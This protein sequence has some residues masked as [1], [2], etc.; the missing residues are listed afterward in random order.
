MWGVERISSRERRFRALSLH[1]GSVWACGRSGGAAVARAALILTT[2]Q[3]ARLSAPGRHTVG[4]IPGLHLRIL[5]PPAS[6][7]LWTLRVVVGTQRR[8]ITLG[9]HPDLSLAEAIEA[10][11]AKR[12]ELLGAGEPQTAS[13]KST[14]P[15]PLWTSRAHSPSPKPPSCTSPPTRR[16][17]SMSGRSSSGGARSN[18]MRRRS[19]GR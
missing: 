15:S 16:G 10:A 19:H 18:S 5:P 7:R 12:Q 3:V 2:A 1:V 17:G 14:V 11:R 9:R 4:T 6:A 8:D 13:P